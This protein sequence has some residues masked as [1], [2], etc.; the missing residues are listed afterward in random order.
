MTA[1]VRIIDAAGNVVR[2]AAVTYDNDAFAYQWEFP[3]DLEPG[4][5]ECILDDNDP[6]A[7]P[8]SIAAVVVPEP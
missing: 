1:E 6:N 8:M 4:R 5:Y 3:A 2:R 7:R